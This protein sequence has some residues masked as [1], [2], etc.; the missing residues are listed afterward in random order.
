MSRS[1]LPG[2][3]EEAGF[4]VV[5]G[6]TD[7]HLKNWSLRYPDTRSARLSP[8][9]DLAAVTAYPSFRNAKLT[10]PIA[11]QNDTRLITPRHFQEFAENLSADVGMVAAVVNDTTQRLKDTWP[12]SFNDPQTPEFVKENVE[13]RVRYLPL[14]QD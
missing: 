2:V 14:M 11:G 3:C 1:R 10:L 7:E 13:N 8:A 4:C 6:N 12:I 9:Y 5:S